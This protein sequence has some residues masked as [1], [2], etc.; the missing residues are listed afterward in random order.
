MAVEAREKLIIR[1]M[2]FSPKKT[3]HRGPKKSTYAYFEQSISS[4][5]INSG[6]KNLKRAEN[7]PL[8]SLETRLRLTRRPRAKNLKY[9]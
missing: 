2:H 4:C 7:F 8:Q 3:L 9:K 6:D 1:W 5:K